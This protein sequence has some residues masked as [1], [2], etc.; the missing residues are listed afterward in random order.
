MQLSVFAVGHCGAAESLARLAGCGIVLVYSDNHGRVIKREL[1]FALNNSPPELADLQAVRLA[2][3]TVKPLARTGSTML[4]ITSLLTYKQLHLVDGE[5]QADS[6]F[7]AALHDAR[8]WLERYPNV[9]LAVIGESA[10]LARAAELARNACTTQRH[11]D[12]GTIQ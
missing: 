9:I 3:A 8:F 12:S 11:F 7:T 4:H 5:Y 6:K 10:E 1:A 2:L